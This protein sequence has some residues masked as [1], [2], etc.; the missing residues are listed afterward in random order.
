MVLS[1]ED[2]TPPQ[3]VVNNVRKVLD[4]KSKY[5]DLVK[6]GTHVGWNRVV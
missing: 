1:K 5:G 3:G 2:R 6:G 4:W